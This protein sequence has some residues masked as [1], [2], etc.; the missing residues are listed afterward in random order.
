[1]RYFKTGLSFVFLFS[2]LSCQFIVATPEPA[3][4]FVHSPSL[5]ACPVFPDDHIWNTPVDKLPLDPNSEA[6]ARSMGID[7]ELRP[8]FGPTYTGGYDGIPYTVVDKSQPFVPIHFVRYGNESDPGPY[9]VPRDAPIED[10]EA[11]NSD[12]HVLVVDKETCILYELYHAYPQAD[13]S[14]KADSGAVFD[15]KK[16]D[17]RPN[18]W[19]SA[20]AA[21]TAILPGLVRYEEVEAGRINHA[22]R[23][24]SPISRN[25][26]V[27]PARHMAST[28]SDK[29][30]PPMG[31]RFRLRADYDVS[32]FSPQT[33]VIIEALK[34]H[35]MI[36]ADGADD[37][38]V[39]FGAPDDRWDVQQ[40]KELRQLSPSDFEAVDV[41]PLKAHPN[42]AR[43]HDASKAEPVQD[44]THNR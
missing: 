26:Y 31:Q 20:D 16:Y 32:S 19:T 3:P 30:A 21:G 37:A 38:W 2:F 34:R 44:T 35:G 17:L 9:P 39:L 22:L 14:W 8:A 23:F 27:W 5:E 43:I 24:A 18:G 40:L 6:Y 25:E 7:R 1:M 15:L 28:I 10:A 13:G 42:S 12:R 11:S 33:L 41:T 36:L 29:N 4:T